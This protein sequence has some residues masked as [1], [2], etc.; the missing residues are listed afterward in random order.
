MRRIA[1]IAAICFVAATTMIIAGWNFGAPEPKAAIATAEAAVAA[2]LI[3][4]FEIMV[5]HGK[6]LPRKH[7]MR[8]EFA[9][10]REKC[11]GSVVSLR[12][13]VFSS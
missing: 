12:Q 11:D 9:G 2:E 3:S 6:S 7:G 13:T 10:L 1:L 8:F 5:R 4:P